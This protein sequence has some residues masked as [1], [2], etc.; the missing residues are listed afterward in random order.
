MFWSNDLTDNTTIQRLSVGRYHLATLKSTQRSTKD[1][2][3]CMLSFGSLMMRK[4]YKI[5][6]YVNDAQGLRA[7]LERESLAIIQSEG[8]PTWV[9]VPGKFVFNLQ[10]GDAI[11]GRVT[12][13]R[14]PY[15]S[16]GHYRWYVVNPTLMKLKPGE[17]QFSNREDAFN[18]LITQYKDLKNECKNV[19]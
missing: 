5:R 7:F 14:V 17:V 4:N 16:E 1:G 11:L 6:T 8:S 13:G 18:C 19:K 2:K 15:D 9:N 10:K 12:R 3:L